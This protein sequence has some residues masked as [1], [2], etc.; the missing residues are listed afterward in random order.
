MAVLVLVQ[1]S[2]YRGVNRSTLNTGG[3]DVQGYASSGWKCGDPLVDPRDLKSYPT[4]SIGTQ[5]WMAANLDV[6]TMIIG[7]RDQADNDTLEKYCYNDSLANCHVYGGIYQW[8]EMMLHDTLEGGAGICPPVK[9]WHVPTDMEWCTLEQTLDPT[10]DCKKTGWRGSD[11]GGKMMEEGN[12]HWYTPTPGVSNASGFTA[13]PAGYR[14][15]AGRFFS[16]GY[17]SDFWSSSQYE[18]DAWNR[19]LYFGYLTVY[20]Y[21]YDKRYGISVRCVK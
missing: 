19:H 8:N 9:G 17:F 20:R 10:A 11:V 15:M 6:G 16:K 18:E 21:R 12:A 3:A 2:S 14:N 1:C 4:V 7:Q 13:L 5:C